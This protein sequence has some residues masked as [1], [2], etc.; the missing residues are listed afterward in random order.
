MKGRE[1]EEEKREKKGRGSACRDSKGKE[2]SKKI[3]FLDQERGFV[4]YV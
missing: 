2:R 3:V 1:E 4:Y